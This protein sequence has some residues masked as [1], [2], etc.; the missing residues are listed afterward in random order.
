MFKDVAPVLRR[1]A[2]IAPSILA[3]AAILF[4]GFA[5]VAHMG[6]HAVS[7]PVFQAEM[8][9]SQHHGHS[10]AAADNERHSVI[11]AASPAGDGMTDGGHDCSMPGCTFAAVPPP[12]FAVAGFAPVSE[13]PFAPGS[14]APSLRPPRLS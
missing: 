1:L 4:W 14:G 3:C 7:E 8:N 2:K 6:H 11:V 13:R 5:S 10:A 9:N 12:A